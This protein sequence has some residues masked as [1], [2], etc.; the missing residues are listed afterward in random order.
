[1][2]PIDT[3]IDL[4]NGDVKM[5]V[6]FFSS[7]VKTSEGVSSLNDIDIAFEYVVGSIDRIVADE[8]SESLTLLTSMIL[9]GMMSVGAAISIN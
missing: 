4:A 5:M 2:S 3:L 8:F 9:R 7:F 1:V 6:P